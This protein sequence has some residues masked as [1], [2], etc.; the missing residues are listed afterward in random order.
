VDE[1]SNAVT[2]MLIKK[3]INQ[4]MPITEEISESALIASIINR[5]K[6]VIKRGQKKMI[7]G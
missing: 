2:N 5:I 1:K 6:L 4:T 7:L 3:T